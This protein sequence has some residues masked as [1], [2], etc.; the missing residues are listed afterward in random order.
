MIFKLTNLLNEFFGYVRAGSIGKRYHQ[1]HYI[2]PRLS[3]HVAF[4]QQTQI[5]LIC[6]EHFKRYTRGDWRQTDRQTD[7]CTSLLFKAPLPPYGPGI[8][9]LNNWKTEF[10][11]CWYLEL[12]CRTDGREPTHKAVIQLMAAEQ[13]VSHVRRHC[14]LIARDG[15]A[16]SAQ[17]RY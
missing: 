12:P 9:K 6:T 5:G 17:S 14:L 7:R 2:R 11:N 16:R 1:R 10:G 3:P 4:R 15:F 13:C 8:N